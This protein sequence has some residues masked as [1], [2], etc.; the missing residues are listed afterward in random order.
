MFSTV[1]VYGV[2]GI[3]EVETL[4][5]QQCFPVMF[6]VMV[7]CQSEGDIDGGELQH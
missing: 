7:L 6:S 2:S 3:V 4:H 1:K 5:V